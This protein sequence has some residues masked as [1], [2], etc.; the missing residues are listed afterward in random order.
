VKEEKLGLF[1]STLCLLL[2][3]CES[4][5]SSPRSLRK[6]QDSNKAK[7]KWKEKGGGRKGSKEMSRD[8]WRRKRR[9]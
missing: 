3:L 1:L 4:Y 6:G 2:F 8:K 5:I 7:T 9:L